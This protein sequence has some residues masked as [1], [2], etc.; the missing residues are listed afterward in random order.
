MDI[1]DDILDTIDL[2]G[3]LYFRT[4]FSAPWAVTVPKHSQAARFHFVIQGQSFICVDSHHKVEL[5]AGDLILIPY[6]SSH[7]IADSPKEKAPALETVLTDSGYRGEGVLVL[8]NGRQDHSTQMVCGHFN[9][10]SKAEHPLINALPS[11]VVVRSGM[12]A[13][14]PLLDNALRMIS[15]ITYESSIGSNAAIKRLSE[16][17]FI[18]LLRLGIDENGPKKSLIH[19]LNDRSVGRALS[20]IHSSPEYPWSLD[21]LAS[22]VAMSRSRFA[23][24][25]KGLVGKSPML[26]LSEWRLQKALALVGDTQCSIQQVANLAGYRSPSSFT[27]AF[28]GRFGMPPKK[29]REEVRNE[30][31]S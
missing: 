1:L 16:V 31:S 15:R 23:E 5:N 21:A 2:K 26:Y 13:Q 19:A 20:L 10:R 18:E 28:Q 8:G 7:V 14:N 4:E 17:V 29:Y 24:R 12:R 25:F 27:R 22:E 9:F 30:R 11:Y 3:S 6:G